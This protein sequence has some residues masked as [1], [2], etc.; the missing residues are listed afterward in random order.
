MLTVRRL[1][2]EGGLVLTRGGRVALSLIGAADPSQDHEPAGIVDRLKLRSV[3]RSNETAAVRQS[4]PVPTT[5]S[6]T[7]G[8]SSAQSACGASAAGQ[9]AV[10]RSSVSR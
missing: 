6:R 9:H 4:A 2:V 1:Y 3:F 5:F 8:A 7:P 10:S